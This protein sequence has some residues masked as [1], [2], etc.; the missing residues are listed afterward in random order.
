MLAGEAAKG[1]Q[2]EVG[3][4][5]VD[6]MLPLV[7]VDSES[8]AHFRL[9][10]AGERRVHAQPRLEAA[11]IKPVVAPE[12]IQDSSE[13][14]GPVFEADGG[15][16]C[17][18]QALLDAADERAGD[19]R[20]LRRAVRGRSDFAAPPGAGPRESGRARRNDRER[21]AIT[22]GTETGVEIDDADAPGA[23]A[24]FPDD[25]AKG[26]VRPCRLPP[27]EE[28]TVRVGV[29]AASDRGLVGLHAA[30]GVAPG[31][32]RRVGPRAAGSVPI[33][34]K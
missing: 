9:D 23:G 6:L 20:R 1:L 22:C 8:L 17:A 7:R 29:L 27:A 31:L 21:L 30:V 24:M 16:F 15:D 33:G 5:G 32:E 34:R 26:L 18:G 12:R 10:V 28:E 19:R 3:A 25:G 14:D 11:R 13:F 4:A 2:D